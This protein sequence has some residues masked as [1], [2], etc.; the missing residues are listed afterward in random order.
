MKSALILFS[1]FMA[2]PIYALEIPLIS[3]D[4]GKLAELL[5]KIP[6]E[7]K[8]ESSVILES[9]PPGQRIRTVFP[10]EEFVFRAECSSDFFLNSPY[11][12][13]STCKLFLNESDPRVKFKNEEYLVVLDD[14]SLAKALYDSISYGRPNK[15]FRSSAKKW[16]V[17]H[18]GA[19]SYIFDYYFKCTEQ[20]CELRFANV[21]KE[22]G[23]ARTRR[24]HE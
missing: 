23:T 5:F 15:E 9:Y 19:N 21:D 24:D 7:F 22:I 11:P 6:S 10:R 2:L 18:D 20:A 8:N 3:W 17:N 13:E 14:P 16:G 12:S 4:Q 1:L